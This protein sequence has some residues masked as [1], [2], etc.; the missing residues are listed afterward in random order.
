MDCRFRL[1]DVTL[2]CSREICGLTGRRV[3][4]ENWKENSMVLKQRGWKYGTWLGAK[5]KVVT[6]RQCHSCV[7]DGKVMSWNII[8]SSW[9]KAKSVFYVAAVI[10]LNRCSAL[11]Q[12]VQLNTAKPLFLSMQCLGSIQCVVKYNLQRPFGLSV[13]LLGSLETNK[14]SKVDINWSLPCRYCVA[15]GCTSLARVLLKSTCQFPPWPFCTSCS[16]AP[17]SV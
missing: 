14:T 8:T 7:S 9:V 4:G 10:I 12:F 17:L 1:L 2:K 6:L 13:R 11:Q 15:C 16:Y 5:L 3:I